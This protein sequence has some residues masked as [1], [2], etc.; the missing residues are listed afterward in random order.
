MRD[1]SENGRAICQYALPRAAALA[2]PFNADLA[3][4]FK[5]GAFRASRQR[6]RADVFAERDE[7]AVD[8]DPVTARELAFERDGSLF[9]RSRR[10]VSP[11]IG[12]AMNVYVDADARLIAGDS[13][14]EV[15]AF[16]PDAFKREQRL[17]LARQRA[18]I[19]SNGAS[20]DSED[21]S[22]LAF[23]KCA[24]ANQLIDFPRHEP[25]D[26]ERRAR[27]REEF[28][29]RR[30]GHFVARSDRDDAGH[31]LLERG[32][33]AVVSQLEHSGLGERANRH[34]DAADDL[35]NVE[36]TLR[37]RH[38]APHCSRCLS[39]SAGPKRSP[40]LSILFRIF[41]IVKSCGVIFPR[42][43]SPHSSGAETVAPGR[44][45]AEY[46]ATT[47]LPRAF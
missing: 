27:P 26:F 3:A 5:H 46:G 28:S 24:V 15:C 32:T 19:F 1:S 10:N 33:E 29:R 45:R 40:F 18:F 41:S 43:T 21:L 37:G 7:Q 30:D 44:G 22:R 38:I 34:P 2:M 39:F 31:E 23:V 16:R 6:A 36:R 8:L 25:A 13:Q 14:R 9:G 12:D 4:E 42:L 47:D 17:G 20:R 35:A 11:S